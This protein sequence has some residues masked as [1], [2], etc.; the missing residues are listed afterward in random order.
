MFC[1]LA[2]L[3]NQTSRALFEPRK[4]RAALSCH[5]NCVGDCPGSIYSGLATLRAD[6]L[7]RDLVASVQDDATCVNVGETVV[8][9]VS[10]WVLR[11][12]NKREDS[13]LDHLG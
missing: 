4:A 10:H 7:E 11:R 2:F 12:L 3:T 13:R 8:G 6:W 9:G 1:G 5:P